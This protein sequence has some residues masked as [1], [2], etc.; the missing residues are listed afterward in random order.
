MRILSMTATFGK[1]DGETLRFHR[2]L[3]VITAPNEWGKSTWCAFMMAMLYGINT[4]QRSK[5]GTIADKERY[6]PWSG[7]PMEGSME[8]EWKGRSITI[9]RRTKGRIP[10]GEFRAFETDSG[11]EVSELTGENCGQMLLGVERSVYLRSGFLSGGDLPVDQDEALSRRLNQLVTTGDDSPAV[12]GLETRLRELRN[13]CQY[14]NKG[15]LPQTREELARVQEELELHGS[16]QG[17]CQ[18]LE[19]DLERLEEAQKALKSHET[20]LRASQNKEKL[21]RLA[22]SRLEEQE[23]KKNLKQMEARCSGL[24]SPEKTREDLQAFDRLEEQIHRLDLDTALENSAIER[25]PV[26]AAFRGLTGQEALAMARQ[27][28]LETERPGEPWWVWAILGLALAGTLFLPK[29]AKLLALVPVLGVCVLLWRRNNREKAQKQAESRLEARYGTRDV[30]EILRQAQAYEDQQEARRVQEEQQQARARV[31]SAR[32]ESLLQKQKAI[33]QGREPLLE[34][35]KQWEALSQAQIAAAAAQHHRK[36]MEAMAQGMEEAPSVKSDLHLNQEET[37]Q[38]LARAAQKLEATRSRLDRLRGQ[39]AG[40]SPQ[41]TLEARQESLQQRVQKLEQ[42]YRAL[43]CA[44]EYLA[45]AQGKLESRF[46][47]RITAAAGEY[48]K[49]LTEGRYQRLL[50]DRDM[51]LS[52]AAQ[53]EGTA[54]PAAWRSEGT[55]DQMYLALRLAVAQV[56][57]P[58]APLILDD[59]F[60]RFDEGRLSAALELLSREQRQV[61]VFSCQEREKRWISEKET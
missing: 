35:L 58:H 50:M 36:A 11:L 23:A 37:R 28:I 5:Q 8:L 53:K 46:A 61:I 4:R 12:M 22:L 56:L 3:N 16:L 6:K 31:F 32:R 51:N 45:M 14:R 57:I 15:L 47:P 43:G 59:V 40:L 30:Q 13:Q 44:Q 17:Q 26:P 2:G 19:R 25:E 10:M 39:Q 33:S 38:A 21:E 18:A 20:F 7:K 1:L 42:W 34:S 24:P 55:V 27:D 49:T 29:L 48:L 54:L 9:E 41:E 60:V 52:A